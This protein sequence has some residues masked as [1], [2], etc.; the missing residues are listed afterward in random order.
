M[1]VFK[2]HAKDPRF[3]TV[4]KHKENNVERSMTAS[5]HEKAKSRIAKLKVFN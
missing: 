3:D 5:C 2:D 1:K 4:A